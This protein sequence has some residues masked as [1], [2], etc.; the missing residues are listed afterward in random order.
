M[1]IHFLNEPFPIQF[2]Q[3][4]QVP[5]K[6][7]MHKIQ[8]MVP[9]RVELPCQHSSLSWQRGQVCSWLGFLSP[10]AIVIH[11]FPL[12]C[13]YDSFKNKSC[14]K[15]KTL[16]SRSCFC[17]VSNSNHMPAIMPLM[18]LSLLWILQLGFLF[19]CFLP[20]A[21]PL[22]FTLEPQLKS[23]PNLSLERLSLKRVPILKYDLQ[24]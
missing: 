15:M 21:N 3:V 2:R 22:R 24:L 10:K 19:L 20:C 12:K 6:Q 9:F 17:S 11:R 14:I 1:L 4:L 16:A 18:L 7:V 13:F 8:V 5:E 23:H